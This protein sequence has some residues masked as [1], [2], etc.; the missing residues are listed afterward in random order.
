MRQILDVNGS[1]HVLEFIF[2]AIQLVNL[3]ITNDHHSIGCF[4]AFVELFHER[5]E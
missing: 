1:L 2:G 3:L 4:V 5:R